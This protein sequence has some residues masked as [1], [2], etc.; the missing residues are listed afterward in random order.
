MRNR[1]VH[2]YDEID[3]DVIWDTAVNSLPNL[4]LELEKVVPPNE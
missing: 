3:L 4:I 1:L 2:E